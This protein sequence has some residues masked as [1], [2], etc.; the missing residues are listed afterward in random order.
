MLVFV[1]SAVVSVFLKLG[2]D[3]AN[4]SYI[5]IHKAFMVTRNIV[6]IVRWSVESTSIKISQIRENNTPALEDYL[7]RVTL[8]LLSV[9]GEFS[10][11]KFF[12]LG[13]P[14]F[15]IDL[16]RGFLIC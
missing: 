5:H 14:R 9:S 10:K 12:N 2:I 11:I 6:L 16:I 15:V 13:T 4:L 3:E 1:L 7:T 8:L